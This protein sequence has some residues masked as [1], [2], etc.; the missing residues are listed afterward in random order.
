MLVK[1]VSVC[2]LYWMQNE[3]VYLFKSLFCD[4]VIDRGTGGMR[5]LLIVPACVINIRRQGDISGGC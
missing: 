4:V 1:T 3:E 2:Y 5:N